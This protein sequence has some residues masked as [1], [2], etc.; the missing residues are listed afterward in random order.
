MENAIIIDAY[1]GKDRRFN[2][3][4][5]IELFFN[6]DG[7]SCGYGGYI[8]G[9][10]KKIITKDLLKTFGVKSLKDLKGKYIRVE[11]DSPCW[12]AK[13]SKIGDIIEDK[14]FSFNNYWE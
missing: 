4:D 6:G 2:M 12:S 5:T 9:D 11:F 14:W 7:W 1:I 3:H 10:K 8:L 13:I